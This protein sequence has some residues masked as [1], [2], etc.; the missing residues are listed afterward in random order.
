MIPANQTAEDWMSLGQAAQ[1]LG[2]HP[3]TLR[4]WADH[5]HLTAHRTQGGHR[6]FRRA[7]VEAHLRTRDGTAPPESAWVF[8]DILRNARLQIGEGRLEKEAWYHKLDNDARHQYRLSG[9]SLVQGL[10]SHLGDSDGSENMQAEARSLGY[11]YASRGM[12][13]GL[14]S[15][16]AA[17]AYLF[18]R[19][20]VMDTIMDAYAASGVSSAQVWGE[21]FRNITTFGD[22]ILIT[23]LETYEAFQRGGK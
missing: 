3:S 22:L 16:E 8:H 5:G 19:T 14:S 18:F 21:M 1:R 9:R 7:D 10:L 23:L 13:C 11:E 2:V 15:V 12:R 17:H 4:S 6:R 20:L